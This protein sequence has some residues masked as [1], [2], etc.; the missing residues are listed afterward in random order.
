MSG[1]EDQPTDRHTVQTFPGEDRVQP[2]VIWAGRILGP[3]TTEA[4]FWQ[5]SDYDFGKIR[6]K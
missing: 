4:L 2:L 3:K 5:S 1:E 6:Q